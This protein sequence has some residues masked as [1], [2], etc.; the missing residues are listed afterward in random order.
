MHGSE[1][2]IALFW[3]VRIVAEGASSGTEVSGIVLRAS[4]GLVMTA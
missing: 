3:L 1:I 2:R 4:Y